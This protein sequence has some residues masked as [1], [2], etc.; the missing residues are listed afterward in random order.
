MP[1]PLSGFLVVEMALAVQ[2]PAAAVYLSDMVAEVIKIEPPDGN[3][4]RFHRGIHNP[5]P[6]GTPGSTGLC[7]KTRTSLA[8][9]GVRLLEFGGQVYLISVLKMLERRF[10]L[11]V[12]GILKRFV[13]RPHRHK[14]RISV[15]TIDNARIGLFSTASNR[16]DINHAIW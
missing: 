15:F 1:E 16:F 2:G 6:I 9:S 7:R 12:H 4:S 14:F 10:K 3:A 11:T 8:A 5:F 13:I